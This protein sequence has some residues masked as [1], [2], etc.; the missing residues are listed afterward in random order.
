MI[1]GKKCKRCG[2]IQPVDEFTT[3]PKEK[4]GLRAECKDCVREY[5]WNYLYGLS[6]DDMKALLASQNYNCAI[7]GE[8]LGGWGKGNTNIDHCH[9]SGVVRGLL[10]QS[11]NIGLGHFKDDASRLL[12]AIEYLNKKNDRKDA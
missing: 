12:A 1:K 2:E 3:N 8:G 9:E 11:C 7:C 4:D 5:K 6:A 10:C